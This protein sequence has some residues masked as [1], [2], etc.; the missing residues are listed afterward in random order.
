[1]YAFTGATGKF[2]KIN[3]TKVT[4]F[5]GATGGARFAS[6]ARIKKDP[7]QIRKLLFFFTFTSLARV[8]FKKNGK[9]KKH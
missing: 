6:V 2:G 3:L 1:M 7:N 4:R 9:E 8:L 5:T